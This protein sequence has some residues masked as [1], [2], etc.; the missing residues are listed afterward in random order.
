MKGK[1]ELLNIIIAL[2]ILAGIIILVSEK[3]KFPKITSC[4]SGV[5]RTIYN[6]YKIPKP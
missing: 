3:E 6:L 1:K 5:N 2:V 4:L